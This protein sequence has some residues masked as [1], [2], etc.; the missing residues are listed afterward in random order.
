MSGGDKGFAIT[1]VALFMG[2]LGCTIVGWPA[3][4]C[5]SIAISAIAFSKGE[6]E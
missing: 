2:A 4:F 5:A 6:Q 1:M 3:L